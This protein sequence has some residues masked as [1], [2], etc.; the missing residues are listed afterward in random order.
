MSYKEK[1]TIVSILSGL[2]LLVIYSFYALSKVQ[3]GVATPDDMKFWATAI[4]TFIVIGVVATII[5][6]IIFHILLSISIAVKGEVKKEIQKEIFKRI[7]NETQNESQIDR[8][9]ESHYNDPCNEQDIEKTIALE[10]VE[11]EMDKL[12]EFKAMRVGYAIAG[13]GFVVSL[14]SLVLEY[15]PAVMLNISFFSFSIGSMIEGIV[16]LFYYKR[17]IQNG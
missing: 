15:A 1:Q 3:S 12:I 9:V 16:K 5:I 17:G 13:I 2:L 7:Q 11:D 10:M 4:L 8:Q 14:I 6:Q